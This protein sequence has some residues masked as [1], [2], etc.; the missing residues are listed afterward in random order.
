MRVAIVQDWLTV[1]GGA[2]KVLREIIHCFP[3]AD[4]FA[5]ID[6]MPEAE[7]KD[8]LHGKRATTSWLQKLPGVEKYYRNLLPFFPNAIESLDFSGYDLI[9]SSSYSVAKGLKKTNESQIHVCYCHSPVRYAWDLKDQYLAEMPWLKRVVFKSIIGRIAKWDLKTANRVDY[10]IANSE[11]VKERI[12]RIYKRESEVIYPPVN[13]SEFIFHQPK[14]DYYFTSARLVPY[15]KVDLIVEAFKQHPDLKLI[16]GGD[17]PELTTLKKM[18]TNNVQFLGYLPQEELIK[19]YQES[20]AF[21]LAANEDFGITSLEAQASGTPVI[22]LRAGGYLETV[23]EGVTG[24]FFDEQSADSLSD[25]I[26]KF[27]NDN[28]IID[29]L[30][31]KD[32]VNSFSVEEFRRKLLL[33]VTKY[34]KRSK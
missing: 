7:R 13:L 20:K 5:L 22:G 31:L 27:E 25:V 14:K 28:L 3:E 9:I 2:E 34:S 4:L 26:T 8:V 30:K 16:V 23:K 15:K 32:H 29:E 18:S 6:F 17:G 12:K 24:V 11:N 21:I 1:N 10:Y 19:H 33:L